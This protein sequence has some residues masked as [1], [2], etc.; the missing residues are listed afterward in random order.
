[1]DQPTPMRGKQGQDWPE[2]GSNGENGINPPKKG[3]GS[4]ENLQTG[5][6]TSRK[7]N[8]QNLLSDEDREKIQQELKSSRA[9]KEMNPDFFSALASPPSTQKL[10]VDVPTSHDAVQQPTVD[11]REN[12]AKGHPKPPPP[13]LLP[14]EPKPQAIIF[15]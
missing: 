7:P 3:G 2:G 4:Q 8:S 9:P 5:W 13:K 1:M 14:K 15:P 12:D 6:Q 11:W 10:V